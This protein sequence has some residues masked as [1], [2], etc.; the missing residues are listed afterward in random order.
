MLVCAALWALCSSQP[1][2]EATHWIRPHLSLHLC[3]SLT[4]ALS[5]HCKPSLQAPCHSCTHSHHPSSPLRTLQPGTAKLSNLLLC[6]LFHISTTAQHSTP[7][8]MHTQPRAM[9]AGPRATHS[10]SPVKHTGTQAQHTC[11]RAHLSRGVCS[12]LGAGR[13]GGGRGCAAPADRPAVP[14]R[15]ARAS[16]KP[17]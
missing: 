13:N 12:S 4:S 14:S 8:P 15:R 17:G 5:L 10:S 3:L 2:A 1:A 11:T 16:P 6:H 7:R 9:H